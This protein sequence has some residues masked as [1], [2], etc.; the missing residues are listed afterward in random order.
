[1]IHSL[2]RQEALTKHLVYVGLAT[3]LAQVRAGEVD[4]RK[5]VVLELAEQE[6]IELATW[7]ERHYKIRPEERQAILQ[8]VRVKNARMAR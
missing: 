8:R 3:R 6:F 5:R 2:P 1:M 7:M 4:E